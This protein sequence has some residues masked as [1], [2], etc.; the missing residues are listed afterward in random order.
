MGTQK[1]GSGWAVI[2]VMAIGAACVAAVGCA[3]APDAPPDAPATVEWRLPD[4]AQTPESPVSAAK[5]IA[6]EA[7]PERR[8]QLVSEY[9]SANPVPEDVE[10]AR[11]A[12]EKSATS[13]A[14]APGLG[15]TSQALVA[16]WQGVDGCV[17]WQ[18][19]GC[20][21]YA[22]CAVNTCNGTYFCQC[23]NVAAGGWGSCGF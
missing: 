17:D 15:R 4:G 20:Q 12:H 7:T 1:R 18:N 16:C 19:G 13:S 14:P 5:R 3:A 8:E 22:Y 2:E 21:V 11:F 9:R 23:D 6:A 10:A